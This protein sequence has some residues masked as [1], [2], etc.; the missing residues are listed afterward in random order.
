MF[1][2]GILWILK[3]HS[4]QTNKFWFITAYEKIPESEMGYVQ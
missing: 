4:A 1:N 2:D 3:I